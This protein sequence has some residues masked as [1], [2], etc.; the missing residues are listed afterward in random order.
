[1]TCFLCGSE[2][3][4]A[5][6]GF[7]YVRDAEMP[8]WHNGARL[9][10]HQSTASVCTACVVSR[11][12][13]VH[14]I[15]PRAAAITALA[16]F[17]VGTLVVLFAVRRVDPTLSFGEALIGALLAGWMSCVMFGSVVFLGLRYNERQAN[18][19][20]DLVMLHRAK[21]GLEGCGGFWTGKLPTFLGYGGRRW[22]T[23]G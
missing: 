16:A 13:K 6:Y 18:F 21:L 8:S 19:A 7:W 10:L 20:I 22:W 2:L 14:R 11:R 15:A 12:T 3:D 1:M 9:P 4:V 17:V 23:I 5:S